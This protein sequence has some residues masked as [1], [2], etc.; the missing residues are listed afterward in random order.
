MKEH[1]LRSPI[2]SEFFASI[3]YRFDLKSNYV[4]EAFRCVSK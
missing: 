1:L 2:K 4:E 3:A